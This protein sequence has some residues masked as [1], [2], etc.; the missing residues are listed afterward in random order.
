MTPA[1]VVIPPK[2]VAAMP[3]D[4]AVIAH[5]ITISGRPQSATSGKEPKYASQKI[6]HAASLITIAATC[7][8]KLTRYSSAPWR[9]AAM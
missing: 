4:V 1:S 7:E 5:S 3:N 9:F 6:S 2:K 8:T